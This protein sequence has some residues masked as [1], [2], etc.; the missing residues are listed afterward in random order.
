MIWGIGLDFGAGLGAVV[1][2]PKGEVGVTLVWDH[3]G[4]IGI[5]VTLQG[6]VAWGAHT[7]VEAS[8]HLHDLRALPLTPNTSDCLQDLPGWAGG[9]GLQA[10]AGLDAAID[11][12]ITSHGLLVVRRGVGL[13]LGGHL[14]FDGHATRK[15]IIPLKTAPC[16]CELTWWEEILRWAP[17]AGDVPLYG[18]L[19]NGTAAAYFLGKAILGN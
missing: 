15:W 17:L 10:G 16:P 2:T 8:I 13:A 5:L 9:I 14:S 11:V 4:S 19:T 7:P 18:Q 12:D 1:V 3:C 6:A